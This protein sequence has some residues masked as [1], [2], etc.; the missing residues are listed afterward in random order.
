MARHKR[1]KKSQHWVPRS[2]LRPWCEKSAKTRDPFLWR[3]SK[4]GIEVK[5]KAPHNIFK[6]SG[7]YT[8][9]T[10]TGDRDLHIEDQ[11]GRIEH[12]FSRVRRQRLSPCLELAPADRAVIC[13]FMSAQQSRTP[14]FREHHR[15]QWGEVLAIA[16]E[17]ELKMRD[18]SVAQKKRAA[19]V[20]IPS[21]GPSL[22]HDEV[23]KIAADP[24]QH[25]MPPTADAMAEIFARMQMIIFCT[26][27]PVGFI[28]SDA[29]CVIFD[30]EWY[31][32]PPIYQAPGLG[33][34]TVEVSMPVAPNRLIVL[35]HRKGLEGY[36]SLGEALLDE[37][38]R[39]T[40]FECHQYFVVNAN[41]TKP[42]W[43]DA[44]ERPDDAWD[45]EAS[46]NAEM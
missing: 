20:G 28:T 43:F 7:I 19:R 21:G 6:E 16:D 37:Y 40:R 14:K 26:D 30:P 3:F 2:Y 8:R 12:A 10:E 39:R 36:Y 4:D 38:N 1:E 24:I 13:A 22:S 46:S 29:P 15:A 33:F 25:L 11:L 27:D 41:T 5:R 44:G 42:I 18:A 32:R 31:K 17:L 23:R 34:P 9:T 45:G 35:T